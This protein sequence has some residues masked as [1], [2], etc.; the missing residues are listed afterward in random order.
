MFEGGGKKKFLVVGDLVN[1]DLSDFGFDSLDF[2][3]FEV[4]VYPAKYGSH[5]SEGSS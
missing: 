3:I 4:L 1:V 5:N 2:F